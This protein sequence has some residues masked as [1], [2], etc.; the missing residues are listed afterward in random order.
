MQVLVLL[1]CACVC[2]ARQHRAARLTV[3]LARFRKEVSRQRPQWP[4]PPDDTA[5]YSSRNCVGAW[6]IYRGLWWALVRTPLCMPI[7]NCKCTSVTHVVYINRPTNECGL[8]GCLTTGEAIPCGWLA[9]WSHARAGRI[10]LSVSLMA[11][12][13]DW[14]ERAVQPKPSSFYTHSNATKRQQLSRQGS[15]LNH[16]NTWMYTPKKKCATNINTKLTVL[17]LVIMTAITQNHSTRRQIVK[18]EKFATTYTGWPKKSKPLPNDH[19]IVLNR[20]KNC[21][22]V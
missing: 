16:R 20:T 10:R 1:L 18:N 19:K 15:R 3:H 5:I 6:L 11:D 2:L 17:K 4:E 21:H 7:Y 8:V 9:R 22:W 13:R 14:R 12:A